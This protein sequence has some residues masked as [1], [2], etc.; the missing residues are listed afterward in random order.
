MKYELRLDSPELDRLGVCCE[1]VENGNIEARCTSV[2]SNGAYNTYS[3]ALRMLASEMVS[4]AKRIEEIASE[5][6]D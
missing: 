5:L 1:M 4:R 2:F 6:V 3:G